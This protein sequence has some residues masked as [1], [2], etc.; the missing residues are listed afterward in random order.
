MEEDSLVY[1]SLDRHR[2]PAGTSLRAS[3]EKGSLRPRREIL[4]SRD[5]RYFKI[6]RSTLMNKTMEAFLPGTPYGASKFP[7]AYQDYDVSGVKCGK[8]GRKETLPAKDSLQR[9]RATYDANSDRAIAEYKQQQAYLNVHESKFKGRQK[10]NSLLRDFLME[11]L[12][13][14]ALIPDDSDQPTQA[15]AIPASQKNSV[16]ISRAS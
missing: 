6:E 9:R 1:E 14:A 12:T 15:S 13:T 11:P 5:R 10:H 4:D 16:N 2:S 7:A 8:G 3:L